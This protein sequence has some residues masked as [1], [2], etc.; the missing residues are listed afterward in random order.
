MITG[1]GGGGEFGVPFKD[2]TLSPSVKQS[3]IC[4]IPVGQEGTIEGLKAMNYIFFL[5]LDNESAMSEVEC[6]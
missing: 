4:S 6:P 3:H 2:R 5:P 1:K